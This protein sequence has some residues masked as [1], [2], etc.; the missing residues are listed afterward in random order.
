[1][2]N[3]EACAEYFKE[4]PAYRRC[5]QELERKWK[6]YGKVTGNILLKNTSEEERRAIGG[7][8]GKEIGRAHV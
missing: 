3:D 5:L 6:S 4:N 1:M 2:N 8:I 7:M